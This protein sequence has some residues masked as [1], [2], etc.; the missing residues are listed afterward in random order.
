MTDNHSQHAPPSAPHR[1]Y[2]EIYHSPLC[3]YCRRALATLDKLNVT[4]E[5]YNVLMNA[6]LKQEMLERSNGRHTVPQIFINQRHIGGSDELAQ[7]EQ[8]GTL[9][10]LLA[11]SPN[12]AR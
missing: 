9:L 5:A 3:G 6:H 2:V 8:E 10:P 11:E 7:L 4:Y 12:S 1:A